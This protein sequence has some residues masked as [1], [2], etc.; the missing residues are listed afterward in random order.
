MR[1]IFKDDRDSSIG[2]GAW[3]C[4]EHFDPVMALL[5]Y[6]VARNA[7]ALLPE[8]AVLYVTE[9]WRPQRIEGRRDRHTDLRA[10]DFT[11]EMEDGRRAT[12]AEY[13]LV[14]EC[15]RAAVGDK[16]YDFAVHGEKTGLHIHAE[17]DPK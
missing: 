12:R 1:I 9:G 10:F 3:V 17:F 14:S 11:I 2:R 8:V 13:V 7:E 16:N 6:K 5:L 4:S 15:T